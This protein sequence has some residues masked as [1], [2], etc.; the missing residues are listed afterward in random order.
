MAVRVAAYVILLTLWQAL[1]MKLVPPA[2]ER[3]NVFNI[4]PSAERRGQIHSPGLL[5][6]FIF[7]KASSPQGDFERKHVAPWQGA[8]MA[9]EHIFRSKVNR[10]HYRR[11]R[12][13]RDPWGKGAFCHYGTVYNPDENLLGVEVGREA[14]DP[15]EN[16][17]PV[18]MDILMLV[19]RFPI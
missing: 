5:I 17:L 1:L 15:K 13:N 19:H 11:Y 4:G 9:M 3:L 10:R 8:L 6:F 16:L 18:K 14:H 12:C 7:Y 2:V